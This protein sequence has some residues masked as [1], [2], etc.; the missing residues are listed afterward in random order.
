MSL[1]LLC[2][3]HMA[4]HI[5]RVPLTSVRKAS[6]VLRLCQKYQLKEQGTIHT[7]H[8]THFLSV[9]SS[10]PSSECVSSAGHE[11]LS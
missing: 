8:V 2:R 1:V 7:P 11:R 4:M 6:K 3:Y 5:E 10:S 9:S